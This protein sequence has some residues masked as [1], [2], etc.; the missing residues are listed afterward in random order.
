MY[1]I[2]ILSVLFNL[3]LVS[4]LLSVSPQVL[5]Q[6]TNTVTYHLVIDETTVNVTGKRRQALAVNHQIPAPVLNFTEGDVAVIHVHNQLTT[7]TSVHWH[8]LLLPNLQDGVS[9]LTTPP[10]LT[11]TTY[12]FTFP[13]K[14]SGTYW[15]HSHT[16]LQEQQGVYGAITSHVVTAHSIHCQRFVQGALDFV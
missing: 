12:T 1:R 9:Y 3:L 5:P 8:G 14:H 15:Y 13:L 11:G 16:G 7:E 6:S 4:C 10:I 2:S